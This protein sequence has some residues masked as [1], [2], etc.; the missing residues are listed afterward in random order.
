MWGQGGHEPQ[1][2]RRLPVVTTRRKPSAQP[3]GVELVCSWPRPRCHCPKVDHVSP[4]LG[5]PASVVAGRS[6]LRS[7]GSGQKTLVSAPVSFMA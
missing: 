2:L 7:G 6:G 3:L 4:S 1:S 5:R